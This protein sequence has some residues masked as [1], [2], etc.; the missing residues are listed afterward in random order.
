MA[1]ASS[2]DTARAFALVMLRQYLHPMSPHKL[3]ERAGAAGQVA[4]RDAVVELLGRERIASLRHKVEECAI[5]V[6][7]HGPWPQLMPVLGQLSAS[8]QP[9]HRQSALA[10]FGGVAENDIDGLRASCLPAVMDAVQRGLGSGHPATQVRALKTMLSLLI[11]GDEPLRAALRPMVPAVFQCVA[12]AASTAEDEAREMLE[13]HMEMFQL[14]PTHFRASLASVVQ[15]MAQIAASSGLE[16]STRNTALGVLLTVGESGKGMARKTPNFAETVVP[17]G[18]SFLLLIEEDLEEWSRNSEDDEDFMSV[19]G[20]AL[21]VEA[22]DRLAMSLGGTIFYRVAWPTVQEFMQS[23]QWVHRHAALMIISEGSEGMAK[24]F[25]QG[26]RLGQIAGV[27]TRHATQDQHPR[28][29]WAA[30][31]ALAQMSTDFA[32]TLQGQHHATIVPAL[33][34]GIRDPNPRV[35][36]HA[37]L[38]VVDF[39]AGAEEE[40][41][42]AYADDA[43][44]ALAALM[45]EPCVKSRESAVAGIAA[46]AA[47]VGEHFGRYYAQLIGP[48]LAIFTEAP[49]RGVDVRMLRAR[50]MEC[51]GMMGAAVGADMFR[52]HAETVMRALMASGQN[53]TADDPQLEYMVKACVNV[54]GV[55]GRDFVP[56]SEYV[57]P[58]LIQLAAR[59]D[60]CYLTD[61]TFQHPKAQ[62]DGYET[63]KLPFRG[64]GE[65]TLV[66]NSSIIE[67]RRIACDALYRYAVTLGAAYAPYIQQTL[68]IMLPLV[69][70]PYNEDMRS[71]AVQILPALMTASVEALKESGQP[72]DAAMGLWRVMYPRLTE[73]LSLESDL[74]SMDGVLSALA[75][76]VRASPQPVPAADV[77]EMHAELKGLIADFAHRRAE[78]AKAREDPDF[79]ER[80]LEEFEAAEEGEAESLGYVT[81]VVMALF[82]NGRLAYLPFFRRDLQAV[83]E[84]MLGPH[85]SVGERCAAICTFAEMCDKCPEQSS[86]F[87]ERFL[88]FCLDHRLDEDED[89]RHAAIYGAGSCARAGGR[90]FAAVAGKVVEAMIEVIQHPS[91]QEEENLPAY[92]NAI[93]TLGK[94][95]VEHGGAV[96]TRT[97]MPQ[98][99]SVLPVPDDGDEEEAAVVHATLM[100]L[101]RAEHPHLLGEGMANLPRIVAVLG[102]VAGTDVAT[103][104]TTADIRLWWKELHA[105]LP[106]AALQQ[107]SSGLTEKQLTR[108][109]KA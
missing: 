80:A 55:L 16:Q 50:A 88:P 104:E 71:S 28:V 48:M 13:V 101:L 43:V 9:A 86:A 52:P 33:L 49:P 29:R 109:N 22:V 39:L 96:D 106:P 47:R 25:K 38:C 73:A 69:R 75:D 14:V 35:R 84:N 5:A 81:N 65:R 87:A 3:W 108:L 23:P 58:P 2:N 93:S 92:Q 20:F 98:W 40:D 64:V 36:R 63:V 7:A 78:R 51:V 70:F 10:I 24:Q 54:C 83:Y 53:A 60:G 41:M 79:D 102:D 99:L 66:I 89:V 31:N 61:G 34:H 103:D 12:E 37:A 74:A 18:L 91:S 27:V 82:A 26:A 30:F 62:A 57:I 19:E 72:A 45:Q 46:V 97:L 42:L 6:A 77:A 17:L 59:E 56:Y 44:T 4:V 95:L 67:E 11:A 1:A 105:R 107:V 21:G 32:G 15:L 94:V 90:A 8:D 100:R 68:E 76:T 85:V